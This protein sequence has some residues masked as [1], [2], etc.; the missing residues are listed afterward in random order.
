LQCREAK[1]LLHQGYSTKAAAAELSFANDSHF[2][3]VFK[4]ACG[5]S[6]QAYALRPPEKMSPIDNDVAARQSFAV[7]KQ[8]GYP[9]N[10]PQKELNDRRKTK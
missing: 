9:Q 2:C 5:V 3:H 8:A 10:A 6:P 1:E 7:P 4:K